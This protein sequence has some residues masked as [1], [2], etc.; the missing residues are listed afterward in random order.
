MC[1]QPVRNFVTLSNHFKGNVHSTNNDKLI[2][3]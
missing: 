2:A 1:L 3:K